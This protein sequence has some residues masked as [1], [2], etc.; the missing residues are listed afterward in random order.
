MKKAKVLVLVLS[1]LMVFSIGN[2]A[3]ADTVGYQG[4]C[5]SNFNTSAAI[6]IINDIQKWHANTYSVYNGYSSTN[7][8]RNH[9]PKA[10]DGGAIFFSW[11]SRA[12]GASTYNNALTFIPDYPG[13]KQ[14]KW[15]FSCNISPSSNDGSYM[16]AKGNLRS[17]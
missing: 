1:M 2:V 14:T 9:I 3:F 6:T 4:R 8:K 7:T 13:Q 12:S 17:Q 15:Y 16:Y 10:R 5:I 11:G